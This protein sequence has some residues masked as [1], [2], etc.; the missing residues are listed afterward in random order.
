MNHITQ[1]VCSDKKLAT[2]IRNGYTYPCKTEGYQTEFTGGLDCLQHRLYRKD[3]SVNAVVP[4]NFKGTGLGLH[5]TTECN[6]VNATKT[7]LTDNF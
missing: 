5:C 3:K 7:H 1:T 6:H 4:K 2:V